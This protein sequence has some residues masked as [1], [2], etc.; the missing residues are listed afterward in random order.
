MSNNVSEISNEN[1]LQR[2]FR[3][4]ALAGMMLVLYLVSTVNGVVIG[5]G[6]AAIMNQAERYD[7]L[8]AQYEVNTIYVRALHAD[9]KAKGFEP[10]P[11]TES[12]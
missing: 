6:I 4:N 7:A 3:D 2:A 1:W 12:E 5:I 11:L 8:R 10:P 9:L